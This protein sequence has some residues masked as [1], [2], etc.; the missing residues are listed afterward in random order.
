MLQ[1]PHQVVVMLLGGNVCCCFIRIGACSQGGTK[2]NQLATG[3]FLSTAGRLMQKGPPREGVLV[4]TA[5]AC[6]A[7]V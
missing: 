7:L 3:R 1:Q 6:K 2:A 4:A 5:P